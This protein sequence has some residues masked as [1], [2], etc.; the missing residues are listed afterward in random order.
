[1][2]GAP[3]PAA[4][5]PP[6]AATAPPPIDTA[7]A[8]PVIDLAPLL[9]DDG[10]VWAACDGGSAPPAAAAAC[11][12][13]AACL[14]ETG[15]V[16]VRD[17]RAGAAD[18]AAFLDLLER[19]FAQPPE[20][21]AAD[22]RPELHYQVNGEGG[23]RERETGREREGHAWARR[24]PATLS[25]PR[26][27]TP[28]PFFRLPSLPL[29]S[30]VGATPEGIEEPACLRPPRRE[31]EAAAL[32][33]LPSTSQPHWPTGADPKWR[34][35]WRLGPRPATTA[36][37]EL[38]AP[39]VVP[40]AFAADW[41]TVLDGWGGKMLGAL[42]TVARA[43]AVGLGLPSAA[44]ADLLAHGPHLLA[45]TGSDLG[46]HA[47]PGTVLAG[48]HV[49]LNLLTVHGRGRLPGLFVWTRAGERLPVSIPPGCL[50]LQAG[51]QLERVTGGAVVAGRHEVIVTQAAV[52]AVRAALASG[53]GPARAWR[54]SS[55]VF[56]H[57]ASDAVLRPLGPF[58][59]RPGV[60]AAY[61]PITAGAFV[62]SELEAICLKRKVGRAGAAG[63]SLDGGG[64]GG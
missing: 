6:P 47:T 2:P 37:P 50:L 24:P 10:D 7:T 39:P 1:M 17:P 5:S 63:V 14:A 55:T 18:A 31:A 45:P 3:P 20:A 16:L 32:A 54:V 11:A 9:A 23:M 36:F 48:Y 26:P 30:Q 28:Y 56:G 61:P 62:Q 33:A 41:A 53:E 44:L 12:A 57:A 34:F 21:K 58:A 49:D 40:A 46:A 52:D 51:L 25:T 43:A 19:Y 8:F 42:D 35:F 29:P 64:E 60:A 22:V 38:N 13:I 59:A 15:C 27:L 4:S